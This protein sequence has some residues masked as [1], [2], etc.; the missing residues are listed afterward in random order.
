MSKLFILAEKEPFKFHSNR[1][2][3][4]IYV[5]FPKI[6]IELEASFKRA[7][8]LLPGMEL[9]TLIEISELWLL[10]NVGWSYFSIIQ[11]TNLTRTVSVVRSG[12]IYQVQFFL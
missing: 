6:F 4:A 7:L 2:N 9:I 1:N 10:R 8:N 5:A 12:A 11:F 3:E